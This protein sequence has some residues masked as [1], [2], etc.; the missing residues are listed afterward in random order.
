M[1]RNKEWWTRLTPEERSELVL[2][3]R[4]QY[5]GGRSSYLPDDCS[6]CGICGEPTL[7]SS[8]CRWCCNRMDELIRK[9]D[10]E[11]IPSG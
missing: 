1:R 3:E 10:G 7:G 2:M 9:G 11:S 6:E 5:K 4:Y 8:P